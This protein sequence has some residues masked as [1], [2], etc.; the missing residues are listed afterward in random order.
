MQNGGNFGL[1]K[2]RVF[3]S[4]SKAIQES[5][6]EKLDRLA[7]TWLAREYAKLDPRAE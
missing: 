1:V 4:R 7:R 2:K 5:V 6:Q 3:V